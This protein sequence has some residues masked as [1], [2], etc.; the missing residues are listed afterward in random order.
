MFIFQVVRE[1]PRVFRSTW[2]MPVTTPICGCST[3]S[4]IPKPRTRTRTR[5]GPRPCPLWTPLGHDQLSL[6]PSGV[7]LYGVW[8][9]WTVSANTKLCPVA[10]CCGQFLIS[11]PT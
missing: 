5:I 6:W 10:C 2:L 9:K 3:P 1:E 7:R 11:S 4:P 8:S